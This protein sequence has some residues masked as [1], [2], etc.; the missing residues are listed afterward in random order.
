MG[1]G[2]SAIVSGGTGDHGPLVPSMDRPRYRATPGPHSYNTVPQY[3]Q[4]YLQ[5][6]AKNGSTLALSCLF[7]VN[8]RGRETWTRKCS[9]KHLIK[10]SPPKIWALDLKLDIEN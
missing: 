4:R 3:L 5:S 1:Q 8:S 6:E 9:A 2:G 7:M 10:L